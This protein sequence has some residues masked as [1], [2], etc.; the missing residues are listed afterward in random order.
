VE[1]STNLLTQRVARSLCRSWASCWDT[2]RHWSKIADYNLPHLYL[3][4]PLGWSG[5][6][7]AEIL[8]T[9]N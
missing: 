9:E 6:N 4:S 5:R 3:A 8:A 2:A 7:F 1:H